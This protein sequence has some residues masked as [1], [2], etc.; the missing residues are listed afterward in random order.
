MKV[1]FVR[2]V[3]ATE[4][5]RFRPGRLSQKVAEISSPSPRPW[6]EF[7]VEVGGL[8]KVLVSTGESERQ[9]KQPSGRLISLLLG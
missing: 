5:A 4:G 1:R 3:E 8:S 2:V 6:M 9:G 7:G